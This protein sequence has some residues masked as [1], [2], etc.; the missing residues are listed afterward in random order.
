MD[1]IPPVPQMKYDT[2]E[3]EIRGRDAYVQQRADRM[4][5]ASEPC[6]TALVANGLGNMIMDTSGEDVLMFS[7]LSMHG[8]LI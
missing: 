4:R 1:K 2:P 7:A 6:L 8:S 3:A 5:K